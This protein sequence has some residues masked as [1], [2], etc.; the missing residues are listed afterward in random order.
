[1]TR[2]HQSTPAELS[3]DIIAGDR[4]SRGSEGEAPPNPAAGTLGLLAYPLLRRHRRTLLPL[5]LLAIAV[6]VVVSLLT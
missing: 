4:A 1:M 3:A 6:L 5:V 2:D